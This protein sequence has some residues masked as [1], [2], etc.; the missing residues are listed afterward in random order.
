M[1]GSSDGCPQCRSKNR[2]DEEEHYSSCS[3][4][5]RLP[6]QHG[7]S[8]KLTCERWHCSDEMFA[9]CQS[10][11]RVFCYEH[12]IE[13]CTFCSSGNITLPKTAN[14]NRPAEEYEVE[15]EAR[16]SLS[17]SMD[18]PVKKKSRRQVVKEC[19]RLGKEFRSEKSSL[20][21]K[22]RNAVKPR[23]T[24][25]P[26][27]RNGVPECGRRKTAGH[28]SLILQHGLSGRAATMD[29]PSREIQGA[30]KWLVQIAARLDQ[31]NTTCRV[32]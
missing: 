18:E 24:S 4:I 7:L 12:F 15:G 25:L 16:E 23:C 19:R 8:V 5:N 22:N 6:S 13:T 11:L 27:E 29:L 10:C 31:L 30:D 32:T 14:T 21:A 2:H 20:V 26:D 17:S 1:R 3:V 28:Q 9:A